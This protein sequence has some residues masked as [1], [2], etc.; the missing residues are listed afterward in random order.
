MQMNLLDQLKTCTQVVA[1]TGDFR[2]MLAFRPT[3]ATTN[4]SLIYA[5]VKDEAYRPLVD[6]AI[7]YARQVARNPAERLQKAM[8]RVAVNFG[9]RI[10]DI[11]P[12]RVSTEVDARL[13]FDTEGTIRK[14]RELIALYEE[15]GA[16]RERILI[17][18]AA[19][20]EGI[21]AAEVL[22]RE[23]IHCNLTLLFSLAQAAC[24][25]EAGVRL[26]SPFVGR[27]LDWH[28]RARGV[29]SIP[30]AEDPGVLSVTRIYNY[31]KHF[32]Y[33][34]QVMGASFRSVGEIVELAGC[35]LL[36]ISPALLRE[37]ESTE[38]ILEKKLDAD[39]AKTLLLERV[40]TD[41][42]SFRWL[43]NEDAMATEKLAE[44]IRNF[45]RDIIRLEE[46]LE[47]EAGM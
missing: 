1:D 11:V 8:D 17:K 15:A 38:G 12:G 4:P 25:A 31:Y 47:T 32:G 39:R 43:M 26:I 37:L 14:A 42:K 46:M 21:R 23:G 35:D 41:E 28:K 40:P 44:G 19:T 6:E 27:I 9:L 24:C 36:T 18:I 5:S 20:W 29:D 34:T 30:P 10:L 7:A 45:T 2:S 3:D 22:E 33:P 16:P 13:S